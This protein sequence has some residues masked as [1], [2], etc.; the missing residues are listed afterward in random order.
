MH[1]G[2]G[3]EKRYLGVYAVGMEASRSRSCALLWECSAVA[4]VF[5][6]GF[7][8]VVLDLMD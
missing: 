7:E 8:A 4:M 6:S 2:L 3:V 5:D 1:H